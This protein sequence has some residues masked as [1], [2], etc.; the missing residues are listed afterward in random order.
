MMG[1]MLYNMTMNMWREERKR[2]KKI[3]CK[4]KQR[5]SHVFGVKCTRRGW[6]LIKHRWVDLNICEKCTRTQSLET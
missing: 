1:H 4:Y 6:L 5:L 3:E 2:F